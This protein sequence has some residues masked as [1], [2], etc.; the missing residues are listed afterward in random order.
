M[1]FYDALAVVIR[2]VKTLFLELY[3]YGFSGC[4]RGVPVAP[5]Q[6]QTG[7][8][9]VPFNVLM[10]LDKIGLYSSFSA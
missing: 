10:H 1:N 5:K 6:H 2:G 4:T 3:K 8:Y 7:L 9:A